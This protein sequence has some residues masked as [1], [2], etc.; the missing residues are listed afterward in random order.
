MATGNPNEE[1]TTTELIDLNNPSN[2]CNMPSY[3]IPVEGATGGLIEFDNPM[4][5]GG[6]YYGEYKSECFIIGKPELDGVFHLSTPRAFAAST[7]IS[8][9]NDQ[10]WVTG[11]LVEATEVST[12]EII[13]LKGNTQPGKALSE[14]F[15]SIG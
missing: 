5:C 10:L 8:G 6:Y 1:A 11:G 9:F 14:C 13:Q 4:F 3:S 7:V 12:S 2:V 15:Y